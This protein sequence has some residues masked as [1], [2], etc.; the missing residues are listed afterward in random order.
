MG[1]PR[2]LRGHTREVTGTQ[3]GPGGLTDQCALELLP[4]VPP[5]VLEPPQSGGQQ[6]LS[7]T[8]RYHKGQDEAGSAAWAERDRPCPTPGG[9]PTPQGPFHPPQVMRH[10]PHSQGRDMHLK[11]VTC[12]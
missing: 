1:W 10:Q 12:I 7:P 6:A 2:G 9:V 4:P 5:M 11:F 8:R 3:T